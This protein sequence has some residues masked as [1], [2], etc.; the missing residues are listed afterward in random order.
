[1][2][3]IQRLLRQL[4]SRLLLFGCLTAKT[5]LLLGDGLSCTQTCIQVVHISFSSTGT[6]HVSA[7]PNTGRTQVLSQITLQLCGFRKSRQAACKGARLRKLSVGATRLRNALG[8]RPHLYTVLQRAINASGKSAFLH[9]RS[10]LNRF[11]NTQT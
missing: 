4:Q 5:S 9:G 10:P 2:P 11:I 1:M 6:W 8:Q 3:I 7:G